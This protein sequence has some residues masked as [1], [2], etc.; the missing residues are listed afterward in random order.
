MRCASE[1]FRLPDSTAARRHGLER[2]VLAREHDG[3]TRA[4]QG[5]PWHDSVAHICRGQQSARSRADRAVPCVMLLG[6][7]VKA[8]LVRGIQVNAVCQINGNIL[9]A[10]EFLQTA[11]SL[12]V[13]GRMPDVITVPR[14]TAGSPRILAAVV[15]LD[16][17]SAVAVLKSYSRRA[18]REPVLKDAD[19][20][21]NLGSEVR[22]RH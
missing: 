16:I 8:A 17:A 9:D 11:E 7:G 1:Q 12:P 21:S 14:A 18:Y 20:L 13:P 22:A 4:G 2:D 3:S 10:V 5:M 6:Q 19:D 15:D